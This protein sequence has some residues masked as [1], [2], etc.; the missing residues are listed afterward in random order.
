MIVFLT[1]IYVGLLVVLV[2]LKIVPLNTF[3]S[4]N[5][6]ARPRFNLASA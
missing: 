6:W 3:F 4:S 2:K 1:L 5:S